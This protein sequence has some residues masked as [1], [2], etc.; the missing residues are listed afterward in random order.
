MNNDSNI[1]HIF[2]KDEHFSIYISSSAIIPPDNRNSR[3]GLSV[4]SSYRY[5][6]ELNLLIEIIK[7]LGKILE[8]LNLRQHCS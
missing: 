2:K 6:L 1:I 5:K 4:A 3:E 8:K 7:I